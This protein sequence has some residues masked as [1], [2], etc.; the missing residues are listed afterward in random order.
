MNIFQIENFL[1]LIEKDYQTPSEFI[2]SLRSQSLKSSSSDDD[3]DYS[4]L[5]GLEGFAVLE[6]DECDKWES[7]E[8][9]SSMSDQDQMKASQP[10]STDDSNSA[11]LTLKEA[12]NTKRVSEISF[13]RPSKIKIAKD[14]CERIFKKLEVFHALKME[15]RDKKGRSDSDDGDDDD[16]KKVGSKKSKKKHRKNDDDDE[17]EKSGSKGTK[18]GAGGKKDNESV[19]DEE[20]EEDD[21][22][23][24]D[25]EEQDICDKT[26]DKEPEWNVEWRG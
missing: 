17:Q 11:E 21:D 23:D 22:D 19:E 8:K 18:K 24:E 3:N 26:I 10:P 20:E 25:L 14:D 1:K 5:R 15:K 4:C 13:L 9:C 12:E 16:A 6:H 2:K 7:S